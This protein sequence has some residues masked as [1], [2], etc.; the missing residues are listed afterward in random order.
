MSKTIRTTSTQR[1]AVVS[2]GTTKL[3]RTTQTRRIAV[4]LAGIRGPGGGPVYVHTQSVANSSWTV[5]HNLGRN[6]LV[7]LFVGGELV[8]GRVTFPT[9]NS[10]LVEFSTPLTGTANCY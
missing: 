4:A 7:T 2:A 1:L 10:A 5:A 3:V 9:V 6:P 8:L